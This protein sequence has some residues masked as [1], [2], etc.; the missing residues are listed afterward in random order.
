MEYALTYLSYAFMK[1]QNL[2]EERTYICD[3]QLQKELKNH[4]SVYICMTTR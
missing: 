4:K 2:Q 1:P 3:H